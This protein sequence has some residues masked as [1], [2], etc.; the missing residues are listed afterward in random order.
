[1]ATASSVAIDLTTC[2]ICLE[3]CKNPKSLGCLHGFC[4]KC[5]EGYFKDKCPRDIVRC[6]VCRKE[7]Q[8]PADGLSGLQPHFILQSLVE[9]QSASSTWLCEVCLGENAGSLDKIPTAT[10]YCVDCDQKLCAQCSTPHKRMK[11]GAHQVKPLG[12][13]LEQ[14]LIKQQRIY[15]DSHEQ[16]QVKLYCHK[17]KKNICLVCASGNHK[18]HTIEDIQELAK[19][20]ASQIESFVKPISLQVDSIRKLSKEREKNINEFVRHHDNIISIIKEQGK[21]VNKVVDNQVAKHVGEVEAIKSE[22]ANKSRAVEEKYR[23]ALA[24]R[25]SFLAHLR[26]TLD[27]GRPSDIVG[28]AGELRKTA[29]ELRNRDVTAVQYKCA[30]YLTLIPADVTQLKHPDL[31]GRVTHLPG[32]GPVTFT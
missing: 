10:M 15:C 22:D 18:Q 31:I 25:E 20:I 7:F 2:S 16:E 14:E 29:T 24:E 26:E 23:L 1:M 6:P 8:L 11:G 12:A 5:L 4:L 21:Q 13:D 9:A 30:P 27:K 3:V 19:K 32:S 28:A 17:C